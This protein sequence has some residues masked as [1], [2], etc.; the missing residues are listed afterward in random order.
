[1]HTA[2]FNF[3]PLAGQHYSPHAIVIVMRIDFIVIIMIGI[4]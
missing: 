2:I 3:F 1:M 4:V